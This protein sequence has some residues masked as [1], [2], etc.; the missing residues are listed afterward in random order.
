MKN[1][2]LIFVFFLTASVSYSQYYWHQSGQIIGDTINNNVGYS[3]SMNKNGHVIVEGSVY[4]DN[5]RG[6]VK[7]FSFINGLWENTGNIKGI[8]ENSAFGYSVDINAD[9]SIIIIGAPYDDYNGHDAGAVYMYQ[10]NNGIWE[11]KGNILY[12]EN[13]DDNLGYSVG[14]SSDGQIMAVSSIYDDNIGSIKAYIFE[15][16]NWEQIGGKIYGDANGNY[17]GHSIAI[18]SDGSIIAGGAIY[19]GINDG[20]YVNVYKNI[21]GNWT[22]EG[23]TI[24]GDAYMD[25][26]SSVS[27]NYSGNIVA[28]G[29]YTNDENGE[30][31]GQV[32]V[33]L[34]NQG[35][36]EQIGSN[37]L[38]EEAHDKF[39]ISTDLNA[40]GNILITSGVSN[41]ND[42]TGSNVGQI[43]VYKNNS[44]NWEQVGESLYG[45]YSND[46]LGWDISIDSSGQNIVASSYNGFV[47]GGG[48]GY[49]NV[50]N[51]TCNK[52]SNID[53]ATCDFYISPN[54]NY[55]NNS[56]VFLDTLQSVNGCDSIIYTYLIINKVDTSIIVTD[57]SL[58]ANSVGQYQWINCETGMFIENSNRNVFI[59][60]ENGTYGVIID[61]GNCIDTSHCY[62]FNNIYVVEILPDIISIYPNPTNHHL[63]INIENNMQSLVRIFDL[64]GKVLIEKHFI[65]HVQIYTESISSGT[66][67]MQINNNNEIITRKIIIE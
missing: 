8:S 13:P 9:G 35:N 19:G 37:L 44:N 67:L 4:F 10:N 63:N 47:N 17:F 34:N 42:N 31:A 54:E 41:D 49:V 29:A 22:Q 60:F 52:Y 57:T 50:Y 7:I 5:S 1:K 6:E 45:E 53:T 20:G 40:E 25:W 61:D 56:G 28:I 30:D 14:L 2:I 58:R 48:S 38:G 59:P 23:N 39:G 33:F 46:N 62:T 24:C 65:K 15:S 66:Y 12:G 16:V 11:L 43:K 3:V 32:K 64:T 36:W 27:L 55:Y 21:S 51:F 18:N 26:F